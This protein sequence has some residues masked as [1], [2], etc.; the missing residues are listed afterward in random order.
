MCF[1]LTF[2]DPHNTEDEEAPRLLSRTSSRG[3]FL[4]SAPDRP[5]SSNSLPKNEKQES[6]RLTQPKRGMIR[7]IVDNF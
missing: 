1:S 2:I 3:M 7:T 6:K 5:V 4:K